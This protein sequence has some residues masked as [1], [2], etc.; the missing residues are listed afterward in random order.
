MVEGDVFRTV[1][2]LDDNYSYDVETLEKFNND[3]AG[4]LNG[5]I[6]GGINGETRKVIID[7]LGKEPKITISGISERTNISARTIERIIAELKSDGTVE[8]IGSKKA[9]YWHVI[10]T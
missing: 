1:V 3:I 10:R 9:G 6:N 5:G 7:I 8:R 4:N 2:P